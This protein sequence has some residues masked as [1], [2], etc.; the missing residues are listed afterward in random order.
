[1]TA[2]TV[3]PAPDPTLPWADRVLLRVEI[4]STAYGTSLDEAQSDHD[5]IGVMST[6]WAA[7]VGL[8]PGHDKT[9][10]YR[11]GRGTYDPSGAGDYDLQVHPARKFAALAA[12]GNP[13]ALM[14]LY[15]P[16]RFSTPLGDQLRSI[17]R[18][19]RSIHARNAF[20]G[21]AKAQRERL[22]GTRC[23][24]HVNREE[25]EA[26]HGYDTKYAMHMLRLG[27]Q[28]VEYMESGTMALPIA[29]EH[30]EFLRSVRRG[31]VP[32]DEVL[33]VAESTERRLHET[34]WDAPAAADMD[35]INDWLLDVHRTTLPVC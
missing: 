4:G 1:M 33:A 27:F 3:Y 12:Q 10:V 7:T 28:G 29:G 34:D 9:I 30:G 2:T 16:V 23:G 14:V 24:R 25:L 26:A 6:P 17:A 32:L 19:F 22:D 5:E 35:T 8:A 18:A 20:L 15:G 13:T 11:P 21:Y 31:E